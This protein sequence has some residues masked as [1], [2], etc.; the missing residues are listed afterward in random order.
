M[1]SA[2]T[3]ATRLVS[4]E[5]DRARLHWLEHPLLAVTEV[6]TTPDTTTVVATRRG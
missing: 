3:P 2:V 4:M 1:A 5:R 6:R